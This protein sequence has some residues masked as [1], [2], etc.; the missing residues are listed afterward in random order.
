MKI[1]KP[2]CL[3]VASSFAFSASA[4]EYNFVAADNTI[5]TKL[6]MSAVENNVKHLRKY[7]NK[8]ERNTK[9]VNQK[10]RIVAR[11]QNC[12]GENIVHFASK[13]GA[14]DTTKLMAKYLT[15]SVTV[16]EEIAQ[17]LEAAQQ[18]NE[19]K[20]IVISGS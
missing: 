20:T 17:N 15:P 4:S 3:I 1:F 9:V 13:Y 2:V 11:N 12:N 19:S 7:A 18:R 10:I 5:G 16:K 14:K 6:C 8:L